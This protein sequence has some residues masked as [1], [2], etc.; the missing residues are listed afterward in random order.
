LGTDQ[1]RVHILHPLGSE[2]RLLSS[3]KDRINSISINAAGTHVASASGDGTVVIVD[4]W[5]SQKE[6][7]A[8][9]NPVNS[10]A[11]HPDYPQKD[12]KYFATCVTNQNLYINTTNYFGH[13]KKK[14]VGGE[15]PVFNCSWAE[16][17]S[18]LAFA[19][20]TG[21]RVFDQENDQPIAFIPRPKGCSDDRKYQCCL[22]WKSPSILLI[23]WGDHIQIVEMNLGGS[24]GATGLM[25]KFSSSSGS[26]NSVRVLRSLG[27]FRLKGFYIAGIAPLN[28]TIIVLAIPNTPNG[29]THAPSVSVDDDDSKVISNS[30]TF[31][32]DG[33]HPELLIVSSDGDIISSD[34]LPIVGYERLAPKD[35]SLVYYGPGS[36]RFQ[37]LSAEI[38]DT[39]FMYFIISPKDVVIAKV[40]DVDDHITFFMQKGQYKNALEEAQKFERDL[41]IHSVRHIQEAFLNHLIAK[42]SYDEAAAIC[43]NLLQG[44]PDLWQSWIAAFSEKG[45]TKAL[46]PYI[47]TENPRLSY[48]T[49]GIV[50][51]DFLVSDHVR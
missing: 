24:R 48:F 28:D 18:L 38:V 33:D 46:A 1:G 19:S 51:R 21:V 32:F 7:F 37:A 34:A 44:D 45:Q 3:H 49:Y 13:R 39:D 25:E 41:R 9:G 6:T 17:S 16:R 2:I 43:P 23:G 36:S 12:G 10:I 4:L 30:Q 8:F 22:C 40:R 27:R 11:I 47:P 26:D 15:P 29:E 31:E 35:F 50:L 14:V 20:T 42:G 5:E